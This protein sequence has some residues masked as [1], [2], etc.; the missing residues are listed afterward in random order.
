MYIDLVTINLCPGQGGGGVKPSG[1][2]EI[3]E[4][5]VYDVYKYSSASVDVHPS[6]SL[7]ETYIST[8][9][10]NITGEFTGG[11]ITVDVPTVGWDQKSMTEGT[12]IITNLDNSASFVASYAFAYNMNIQTVNLP[13]ATS[14]GNFAFYRCYSLTQVNLP[15]CS[16]IG[17]EAFYDTNL[18]SLTLGS[19]SVVSLSGDNQ[20]FPTDI[21]SIYVPGSLYN[22]YITNHKWISYSSHIVEPLIWYDNGTLGGSITEMSRTDWESLGI[23]GADIQRVNFDNAGSF[24]TG[25][26]KD[27]TNLSQVNLN[28]WQHTESEV[29]MG[30]TSLESITHTDLHQGGLILGDTRGLFSGCT[31]L[32]SLGSYIFNSLGDYMFAGTALTSYKLYP[33]TNYIGNYVF[34]S[35]TSLTEIDLKDMK[36]IVEA[37][38]SIFDGCTNL[39]VI[40]INN[41]GYRTAQGWSEYSSL[42]SLINNTPALSFENGLLY[43]SI[44]AI[45]ST[46][47]TELRIS[48]IDILYVSLPNCTSVSMATFRFCYELTSVSLP[49]CE[50][51]GKGVFQRCRSLDSI[52][53]PVVSIIDSYCFNDCS[54]LSQV[55]LP[56]CSYIGENAFQ[57]C[58]LLSIITIGYSGVC[59]LPYDAFNGTTIGDGTGSIYVPASLVDAYKT[60]ENWSMYSSQIFT[61]PS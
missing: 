37:G 33:Y 4:N 5:G 35:C 26:F 47:W 58:Y 20:F 22:Q 3:S 41:E 57:D 24:S 25:T 52:Y 18:T 29:F 44:S 7:S 40:Y 34:Q 6:A 8:G 48:P 14:V 61:I 46:D 43:G 27:C 30:C 17:N 13:Y 50:N 55:S 1:T 39:S 56:V 10:Y 9:S 49:M 53:L 45:S 51:L 32:S 42:M 2:L 28:N 16:F 15:V 19:N 38:T 59:S 11:V 23:S 31:N 36:S 54:S 21:L 12:N 60:A